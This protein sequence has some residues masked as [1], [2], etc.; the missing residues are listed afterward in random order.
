[1]G[2]VI[3]RFERKG[4]KLKGLKMFQTPRA[5]AEEHYVE[6][7]GKSFY[8]NLVDYIVSGPVVAMVS[9]TPAS[10]SPRSGPPLLLMHRADAFLCLQACHVRWGHDDSGRFLCLLTHCGS[11]SLWLVVVKAAAMCQS[12]YAK[13]RKP[14]L[15]NGIVQAYALTRTVFDS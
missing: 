12:Q 1:M 8:N 9:S 6:H 2:E 3:G 4:F 14:A 10:F 7:V 15:L 13:L 5:L 11:S